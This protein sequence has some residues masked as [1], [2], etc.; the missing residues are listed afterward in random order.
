M[1]IAKTKMITVLGMATVLMFAST[2]LFAGS[3]SLSGEAGYFFGRVLPS[4]SW[5]PSG[6]SSSNVD[7]FR[8]GN[9]I[10]TTAND[11]GW[12]TAYFGP[13]SGSANYWICEAGSTSW[14]NSSTCS[15][16]KTVSW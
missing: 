16:V 4:L 7:V 13:S 8:D 3:W 10:A 1:K 12:A 14:Y 2:T 15:N 9:K 5:S 11:G 6:C